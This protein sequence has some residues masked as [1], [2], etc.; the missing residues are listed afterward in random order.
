MKTQVTYKKGPSV[1][2]MGHGLNHVDVYLAMIQTKVQS[3]RPY[4]LWQD[5]VPI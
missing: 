1:C 3:D 5:F 4:D 2:H